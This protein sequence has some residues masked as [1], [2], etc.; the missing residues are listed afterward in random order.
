M[1]VSLKDL[2]PEDKQALLEEA[3]LEQQEKS[4]KDKPKTSDLFDAQV[5][6]KKE[7][8]VVL[9]KAQAFWRPDQDIDGTEIADSFTL[10]VMNPDLLVSPVL[11]LK[12][13]AIDAVRKAVNKAI[14]RVV[15]VDHKEV[16]VEGKRLDKGSIKV[17]FDHPNEDEAGK[18]LNLE[19]AKALVEIDKVGNI[20]TLNFMLEAERQGKN[21][22]KRTRT[23]IVT[24]IHDRVRAINNATPGVAKMGPIIEEEPDPKDETTKK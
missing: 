6:T 22:A 20:A 10:N 3:L 18:I 24:A 21:L 4:R 5:G 15:P 13:K 23:N 17:R 1:A 7:F 9:C 14:L 8:R 19:D 2:S 16:F 11:T 12:H